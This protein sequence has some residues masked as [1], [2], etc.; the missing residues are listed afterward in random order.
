MRKTKIIC[1]M[2]P[3]TMDQ[4]V[5]KKLCLGGMN[6]ARMNFSHGSHDSHLEQ[7]NLLQEIREQLGLPIGTMCDTKGP[8]I[9]TGLFHGGKAVLKAGGTFTFYGDGR[10]GDETGC[11]TS[12][13]NLSHVVEPGVRICVDDGLIE[14]IVREISGDNVIC[15]VAN[16]GEVKDHKGINL[17]GTPVDLPFLSPPRIAVIFC[18][19]WKTAL[20]SLRPPSPV[21]L[22][23]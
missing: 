21:R 3:A 22:R 7:L 23:T 9:R 6:V 5:L 8:E 11:S 18:L 20:T 14:L 13:P 19:Q 1:T 17:P 10:M 12:Y 2:G 4:E 16:G 15:T